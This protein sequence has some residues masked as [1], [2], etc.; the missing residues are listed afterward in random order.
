MVKLKDEL[1]RIF[2]IGNLTEFKSSD[3]VFSL[4][5]PTLSRAIADINDSLWN[6]N[7][8]Y[9]LSVASSNDP[10]SPISSFSDFVFQI[11]PS[12]IRQDEDFSILARPTQTGVSVEHEGF[13]FKRITISGRH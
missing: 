7:P 13:V 6:Q 5:N 3:Q 9:S 1:S 10:F 8:G 2:P 11:N 12:A 4:N